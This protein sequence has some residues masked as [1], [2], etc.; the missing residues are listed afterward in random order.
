MMKKILS[1][2]SVLLL[3][4]SA[5][6]FQATV[7]AAN[8]IDL[9]RSCS[10]SIEYGYDGKFFEG[11]TVC[12]YKIADVYENGTYE[13]TEPF[14]SLSVNIY[15]ITTQAEWK[16]VASTLAS[17][18]AADSIAPTYKMTTDENGCVAFK[19]ISAGMYLTLEVQTV[20][21]ETVITFENFITAVPSPKDEEEHL[22][23]V[24]ARPK[25]SSYTPTKK[26]LEHK[27]VKQWKDE[28]NIHNR[29]QSV[30][31]DILRN[32]E[33]YSTQI[34]SSENNWSYS[35]NYEDDG[36]KWQ[37][38]ERNISD[39]YHVTVESDKTTITITNSCFKAPE[40]P[41]Q[42]NDINTTH[43]YVILM[44]FS[45]ILLMIMALFLK[46]SER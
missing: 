25:Y 37:A 26:E 43:P 18:I 34:L 22:Y 11:L 36:S 6:L 24:Y 17:Y 8:P 3:L 7:C 20:S 21:D 46:R 13:L 1:V 5:T 19:N 41:P 15:G 12:T 42:T 32:G 40:N 29:P 23:D 45:G 2:I 9:N 14:K 30:E 28:G 27:I 31:V 33:L 35:W 44:S 10:L 38:V 16:V 39:D 4:L